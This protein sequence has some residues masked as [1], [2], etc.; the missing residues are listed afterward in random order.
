M[1]CKGF[2]LMMLLSY[3]FFIP[4]NSCIPPSDYDIQKEIVKLQFDN[5]GWEECKEHFDNLTKDAPLALWGY[6]PNCKKYCQRQIDKNNEIIEK[7]EKKL[8]GKAFY[9]G[10]TSYE[11][12]EVEYNR[13]SEMIEILEDGDKLSERDQQIYEV[14][15]KR[16]NLIETGDL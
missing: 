1:I 13:I 5:N 15:K 16:I 3:C 4:I 14:T 2:T 10:L 8:N 9:M 11:K 12:K 6:Y 7:L